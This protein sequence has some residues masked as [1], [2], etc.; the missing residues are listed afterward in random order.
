MRPGSDHDDRIPLIF[1]CDKKNDSELLFETYLQSIGLGDCFQFEPLFEGRAKRPDYQVIFNDIECLFE[2]KEIRNSRVEEKN[3]EEQRSM[4]SCP[5]NIDPYAPIRAKITEASRKFREFPETRNSLV[6]CNRSR[7]KTIIAPHV[8]MGAM[9]GDYGIT[10]PFTK[11]GVLSISQSRTSFLRQRGKMV[12]NYGKKQFQNSR[13]NSLITVDWFSDFRP[14]FTS[15]MMS[16]KDSIANEKGRSLTR[17][18]SA[19][20][21]IKGVKNTPRDAMKIEGPQVR[22]FHNPFANPETAFPDSWFLGPFDE[23]WVYK[24]GNPLR[25]FAGDSLRAVERDRQ[26]SSINETDDSNY[27]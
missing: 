15:R 19:I 17:R 8:L 25:V 22:V 21:T 12:R 20:I 10:I 2:V 9:V 6:I 14:E 26:L 1:M 27:I 18:E 13:I 16:L 24:N 7:G 5:K 3:Y 4:I 23:H 11:N